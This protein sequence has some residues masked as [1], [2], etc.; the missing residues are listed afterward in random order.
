[1][2]R[3]DTDI[4]SYPRINPAFAP[5]IVD[6]NEVHFSTGPWSGPVFEITDEDADGNLAHLVSLLDGKHHLDTICESFDSTDRDDIESVIRALQEK[7]IVRDVGS[8]IDERRANVAGYFSL[9]DNGNEPL[10]RIAD[11]QLTVVGAGTTGT[12][13][14]EDFLGSGV[15]EITYIDIS[16][17][18]D[19]LL[20]STYADRL[21]ILT[22]AA[23]VDH[24]AAVDFVIFAADEPYPDVVSEINETA[25]KSGT[26]WTMGVLNGLDGQ[27]GPTVYPGET[28][29]FECFRTRADAANDSRIAYAQYAEARKLTGALLPS[30]ARI[31]AGFVVVDVL[32]QL[33]GGFGHTTGCVIDFDFYDF[34]VEANE[35]LRLPRCNTCGKTDER[36]DSP[37]HLTL[38]GLIE[39]L[40]RED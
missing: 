28:A 9:Y 29:C 5:I 15:A 40:H 17:D 33:A 7:S 24:L 38:D 12:A 31:V 14:V 2:S 13:V 10:R 6:D 39:D 18:T 4:A 25:Q 37:R 23:I 16:G 21:T 35:V 27:V 3:E 22:E 1:M 8:P 36:L 30:F 11:A 20:P 26:P 19:D 32:V 34:A